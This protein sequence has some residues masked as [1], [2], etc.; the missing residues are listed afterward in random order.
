MDW[1]TPNHK[2]VRREPPAPHRVE[3]CWQLRRESGRVLEC[4]ITADEFGLEVRIRYGDTGLVYSQRVPSIER[5][6]ELAEDRRQ[7]VLK[8]GGFSVAETPG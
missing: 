4:V 1:A 2:P 8:R 5:G 3:T 6:R 7:A